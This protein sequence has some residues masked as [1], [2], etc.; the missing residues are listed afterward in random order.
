MKTLAAVIVLTLCT[1]ARAGD[2][3]LFAVSEGLGSLIAS[4]EPCGLTFSHDAVGRWIE[5][6][7][8]ADNI[9]FPNFLDR[10][11]EGHKMAI[12]DLSATALVARCAQIAR[13][14]KSHGFID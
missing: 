11:I 13:A 2:F 6:N 10:A 12:A 1:W 3:D 14:A 9:D 5:A 8:P 4:E 7:V